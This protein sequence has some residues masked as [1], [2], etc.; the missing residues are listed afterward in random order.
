MLFKISRNK[1]KTSSYPMKVKY[2][3]NNSNFRP[4]KEFFKFLFFNFNNFILRILNEY[5]YNNLKAGS[6]CILLFL[7]FIFKTIYN[8]FFINLFYI[9]SFLLSLFFITLFFVFDFSEKKVNEKNF[10]Y[11]YW[12]LWSVCIIKIN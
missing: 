1:F 3:K 2:F 5:F 9:E 12:P 6:I 10:N 4:S 8:I 11:W 7:F